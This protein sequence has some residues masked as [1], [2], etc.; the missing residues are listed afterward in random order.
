EVSQPSTVSVLRAT[1]QPAKAATGAHGQ[2]DSTTPQPAPGQAAN[3]R[4]SGVQ[5]GVH[6]ISAVPQGPQAGEPLK[7]E[8][9][10]GS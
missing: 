7:A 4:A 6:Q 1:R 10:D 9:E 5:S 8:Y 2:V 3:R